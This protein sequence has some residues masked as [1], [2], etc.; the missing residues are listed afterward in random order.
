MESTETSP[1]LLGPHTHTTSPTIDLS[2][3]GGTFIT[4]DEAALTHHHAKPRVYIR[5]HS[6]WCTSYG[7][8]H[9]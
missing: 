1:V 9:M 8:D 3:H 6:W 2:H 7:F 4:A 5:A